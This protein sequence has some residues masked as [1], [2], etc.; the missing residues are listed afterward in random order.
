[1]KKMVMV[2]MMVF[3]LSVGFVSC[4]T[5]SSVDNGVYIDCREM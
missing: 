1:M 2:L 5:T 4:A 3:G